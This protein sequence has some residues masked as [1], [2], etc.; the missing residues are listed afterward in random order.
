MGPISIHITKVVGFLVSS[1][2][3]QRL[4]WKQIQI[5]DPL[6]LH[7]ALVLI[8]RYYVYNVYV[9]VDMMAIPTNLL[10]IQLLLA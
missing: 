3:L 7:L 10:I 2:I 4:H 8:L 5:A 1:T 6:I 9:Y